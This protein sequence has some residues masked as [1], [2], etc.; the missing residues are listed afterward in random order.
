MSDK[1]HI[2]RLFQE[3]FKDFN[4]APNPEVWANIEKQLAS[5]KATSSTMPL[6]LKLSSVA[7]VLLVFSTLSYFY[8]NNSNTSNTTVVVQNNGSK[9][10][11]NANKSTKNETTNSFNKNE[12]YLT[13]SNSENSLNTERNSTL[14]KSKNKTLNKVNSTTSTS[15]DAIANNRKQNSKRNLIETTKAKN[16][17]SNYKPNKSGLSNT[18]INSTNLV[19]NSVEKNEANHTESNSNNTLVNSN[20]SSNKITSSSKENTTKT[21]NNNNNT[22]PLINSKSNT[23]LVSSSKNKANNLSNNASINNSV[24]NNSLAGANSTKNI[25]INSKKESLN[26]FERNGIKS[27]PLLTETQPLL[28]LKTDAL[29]ATLLNLKDRNS[30]EAAI[31]ENQLLLEKEAIGKRWA[32][33][34]NIAPVY[35]NSFGTGSQFHSQF[36]NNK[37]SGETNTSYGI[38]V[39]YA[40]DKDFRIRTGIHQVNLSYDTDNVIVFESVSTTP[41][42]NPL[43]NITFSNQISSQGIS[44]ISNT[45][46]A[47][48]QI[49]STLNDNF[50]AALSQRIQYIE[51][52]V[53]LEYRLSKKKFGV[54]IIG[55][56]SSFILS[57]NQV[58][59]EFDGY[60]TE[61]GKANNINNL[62]FSTNLGIGLNYSFSKSFVYNFEPTFKYQINGFSNTSGNFNPYII[63]VYTGFS[64]K[65]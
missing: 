59:S 56:F 15:N 3:K 50:N 43:K 29:Q 7:A 41:N 60:N 58:V 61:L 65:F 34:P 14:N 57:D 54:T 64:Y 55:G 5:N 47:A 63:G 33:S 28:K 13:D 21:S 36:I 22:N 35:Y 38:T 11:L 52:P 39:G 44:V 4:Q 26:D 18:L 31:A 62:S 37:K 46:F 53:E 8:I 16:L 40:L 25:G 24:N 6:W 42:E 48:Q 32:I 17:T 51:I 45:N 1:K 30:I 9:D 23:P 19:S 49:S 20:N 2:D 12:D 27:L 10:E